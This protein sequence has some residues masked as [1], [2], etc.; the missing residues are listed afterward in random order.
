MSLINKVNSKSTEHQIYTNALEWVKE[1]GKIIKSLTANDLNVDMKAG[2]W[3]LVTIVDKEIETWLVG[4]INDHY[5]DHNIIGEENIDNRS[6]DGGYMWI[7]DP[8]DGTTNMINRMQDFAV[9]VALCTPT[10]GIF[11]IVYDVMSDQLYH[12]FKGEGAFLNDKRLDMLPAQSRLK[13]ELLAI[14]LPWN[15]MDESEQW[16]KYM[17]LASKARGIR[18]FGATAIELCDMANGKLGAYFQYEVNSYDYAASRV[19]LEELGCTFSDLYGSSIEWTHNGSV[20]ASTP[21]IHAEM[22]RSLKGYREASR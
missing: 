4:N 20:V 12:S 1:A 22:V 11:G 8:I 9:S 2:H 17:R 18:V 10:E 6:L 14:T 7:I 21:D 13:D 15:K 3:D 19:I 5:P 16:Y